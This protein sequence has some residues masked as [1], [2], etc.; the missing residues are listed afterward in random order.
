[1][2][3]AVE[4]LRLAR[5]FWCKVWRGRCGMIFLLLLCDFLGVGVLLSTEGLLFGVVLSLL[6]CC[7]GLFCF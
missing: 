2:F 6:F 1:V 4:G 3:D 5:G 7:F